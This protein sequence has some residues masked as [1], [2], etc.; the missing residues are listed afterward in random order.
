MECDWP[1]SPL[2][3]AD[4]R[5]LTLTT[6][7]S[8]VQPSFSW[9]VLDLISDYD[10][11]TNMDTHTDTLDPTLPKHIIHWYDLAPYQGHMVSFQ[12]G[13]DM[14][15]C[16]GYVKMGMYFFQKRESS[17]EVA[18]SYEILEFGDVTI[19]N[20]IVN[21]EWLHVQPFHVRCL[22]QREFYDVILDLKVSPFLWLSLQ[23]SQDLLSRS[24]H[25]P[26]FEKNRN[27]YIMPH[28]GNILTYE[29]DKD[30]LD[31]INHLLHRY[32]SQQ[33]RKTSPF[34]TV[35]EFLIQELIKSFA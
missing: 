24:P 13:E 12:R 32:H 21:D 17:W 15:W 23:E 20:F 9:G 25:E 4:S 26:P 29:Y 35:N 5:R 11:D 8:R 2:D 6:F 18:P 3:K 31:K 1:I 14:P 27:I 33:L 19:L 16:Y 28:E 7:L 22:K 10:A 30:L 34:G